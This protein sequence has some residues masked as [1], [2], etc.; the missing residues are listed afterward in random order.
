MCFRFTTGDEQ[1]EFPEFVV[2]LDD[3]LC[4]D[5]VV[6]SIA[7]SGAFLLFIRISFISGMLGRL[8]FPNDGSIGTIFSF[9]NLFNSG[10]IIGGNMR[11]NLFNG[12]GSG[13]FGTEN[14]INI[15]GGLIGSSFSFMLPDAEEEDDDD[16]SDESDSELTVDFKSNSEFELGVVIDDPVI[17]LVVKTLAL[18]FRL[19]LVIVDFLSFTGL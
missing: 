12:I 4:I 15:A 8:W 19:L 6:K 7:G 16:E 5:L 9:G 18:F 3:A 10:T 1:S 14:G 2:L 11:L 13:S 17:L